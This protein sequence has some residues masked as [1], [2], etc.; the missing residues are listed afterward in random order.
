MASNQDQRFTI[1]DLQIAAGLLQTSERAFGSRWTSTRMYTVSERRALF[2]ERQA[3]HRRQLEKHS[4]ICA[5][6]IKHDGCEYIDP[7]ASWLHPPKHL[8]CLETL[9]IDWDTH[10]NCCEAMYVL[11]C[12]HCL[13]ELMGRFV[14]GFGIRDERDLSEVHVRNLTH[15]F[16]ALFGRPEQVALP[17]PVQVQTAQP[18]SIQNQA[19]QSQDDQNTDVAPQSQP[20]PTQQLKAIANGHPHQGWSVYAT[21]PESALDNRKSIQWLLDLG[22]VSSPRT[23]SFIDRS[24]AAWKAG[25]GEKSAWDSEERRRLRMAESKSRQ[26]AETAESSRGTASTAS[27]SSYPGTVTQPESFGLPNSFGPLSFL[28]EE[29]DQNVAEPEEE[30]AEPKDADEQK[31]AEDLPRRAFPTHRPYV[32]PMARTADSPFSSLQ[33]KKERIAERSGRLGESATAENTPSRPS[34]RHSLS[35]GQSWRQ[36]PYRDERKN[37]SN[38]NRPHTDGR[39][40][41]W[42]RKEE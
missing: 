11:Y 31:P 12:N 34:T 20:A 27:A 9:R 40:K 19:A 26:Q 2:R 41:D 8:D 36:S 30:V 32:P 35:F 13:D 42:R 24:P 23:P 38:M 33:K 3:L 14:Q 28:P 10:E 16:K 39:D 37:S 5:K 22:Q 15:I 1:V 18:P 29:P 17:Q 25:E 7:K 6:S 21:V 4:V